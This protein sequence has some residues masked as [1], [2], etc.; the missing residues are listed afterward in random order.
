[1]DLHDEADVNTDG[2]SGHGIQ[3]LSPKR[4]DKATS[5]TGQLST[6][7]MIQVANHNMH[8]S[9]SEE[10]TGGNWADVIQQHSLRPPSANFGNAAAYQDN[11]TCGTTTVTLRDTHPFSWLGP[12][13]DFNVGNCKGFISANAR[14]Y[15]PLWCHKGWHKCSK[16]LRGGTPCGTPSHGA[17]TCQGRRWCAVL[18]WHAI[19]IA[20]FSSEASQ[21]VP[22]TPS[23]ATTRGD[24]RCTRQQSPGKAQKRAHTSPTEADDAHS[25]VSHL[26]I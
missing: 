18:T 4:A 5:S 15:G 2:E 1:M 26:H 16:V 25:A 8:P 19:H 20:P 13:P 3:Q 23:V 22:S 17:H 14:G 6:G 12:C 24:P 11:H 9:T 7:S 10:P 21:A